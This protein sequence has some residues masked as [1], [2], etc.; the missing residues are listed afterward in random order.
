MG[1]VCRFRK[2]AFHSVSPIFEQLTGPCM[3]R[4]VHTWQ[5]AVR[6]PTATLLQHT[7]TEF[8]FPLLSF[9]IHGACSS[10]CLPPR[11]EE[12]DKQL[13]RLFLEACLWLYTVL[14]IGI[15]KIPSMKAVVFHAATPWLARGS[16]LPAV[17]RQA[18]YLTDKAVSY[19]HLTLP[20]KLEV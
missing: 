10:S 1:T 7:P 14:R 18:A 16:W 6:Y 17:N 2:T 15:L 5:E 3:Y 8:A 13:P 9:A 12:R 19:T 11:G 20:T 4:P